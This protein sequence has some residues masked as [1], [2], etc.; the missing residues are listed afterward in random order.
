MEIL[1]HLHIL[2]V[3]LKRFPEKTFQRLVFEQNIKY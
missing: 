3:L 2:I 1:L